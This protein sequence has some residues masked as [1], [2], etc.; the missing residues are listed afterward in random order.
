MTDVL[1]IKP[2]KDY[3]VPQDR[4]AALIQ[5]LPPAKTF[6]YAL[7]RGMRGHEV[8]ALQVLLNQLTRSANDLVEDGVFGPLT[9]AQVRGVQ[10]T[11]GL[12]QDGVA[13]IKTQTALLLRAIKKYEAEFALPK[14]LLYGITEGES[15]FAVGCVN[16][17]IVGGVDA[18]SIQDRV[19]ASEY[20]S[21]ARWRLAFGEESIR[22]VAAMLASTKARF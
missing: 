8:Y 10:K 9:E 20:D 21:A 16:W 1:P 12:V 17:S 15:G 6:R 13:G 2:Q 18:G 7:K 14:K 5:F 11:E 19:Y 4:A 3:D 22:A